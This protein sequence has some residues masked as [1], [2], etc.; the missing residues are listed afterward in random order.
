MAW[1]FGSVLISG[2][3]VLG[4]A[5]RADAAPIVAPVAAT[6]DIGGPGFGLISETFDQ[7][8][9]SANYT[10]GVTDF[11]AFLAGDP[12]HTSMYSGFEWF[13]NEFQT[14]VRVTYDLGQEYNVSRLALWN[15]ESSGI[16]V[17]NLSYSLNGTDFFVLAQN[18]VPT[19][20]IALDAEGHSMEQPLPPFYL[21][22][23]FPFAPTNARYIRFDMSECA[24]GN[25]DF[26]ACA[27]GEVAFD[28]AVVPEPATILLLGS[29]L[30][31][32]TLGRRRRLRA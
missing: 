24:Q 32:L 21:A 10:S 13:S 19:D 3:I 6:I 8:G 18:L 26:Q 27:I 4:V 14:T 1:K 23:V 15:E 29:G 9:L 22:D 20:N 30:A 25:D 2:A 28:A 16:G 11:D 17:L 5:V 7:S 12:T 31:A